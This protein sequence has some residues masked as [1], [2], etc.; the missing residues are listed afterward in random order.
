MQIPLEDIVRRLLLAGLPFAPLGCADGPALETFD[1]AVPPAQVGSLLVDAGAP[2]AMWSWPYPDCGLPTAADADAALADAS[3]DQGS[4][5]VGSGEPG[6][7]GAFDGGGGDR[8]RCYA[9]ACGGRRPPGLIE[10]GPAPG[11]EPGALFARA[12]ALEA[13]SVPA[14]QQLAAELALHGAPPAFVGS[15][16]RAVGEEARHFLVTSRLAARHGARA[17]A[18]RV[19]PTPLRSLEQMALDNA[20]EGC[21]NETHAALI[22]LHQAD[23]AGDRI[24][25]AAM[26][27]IATEEVRHARLSWAIDGWCQT[28]LSPTAR[29]RLDQARAEAHHR[30][31][32]AAATSTSG[33]ALR[34]SLGL[35]DTERGLAMARNVSR[36]GVDCLRRSSG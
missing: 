11:A 6:D 16:R 20:V 7:G 10:D 25:R 33:P 17:R 14:F 36:A 19:R 1:P 23:A 24:V 29:R 2:D 13:A 30:L 12:A 21:V 5:E 31:L 27:T 8:H 32:A 28:R 3:P 18:P 35:P 34:R 9:M 15:A 26:R 4:A 22:A